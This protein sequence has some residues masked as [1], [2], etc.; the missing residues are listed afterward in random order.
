M[1]ADTKAAL[2][3][4]IAAHLADEADGAMVTAYTLVVANITG[5]PAMSLPL[6]WT[7]PTTE[8][9][10]GL[11]IGTHALTRPGADARL[12]SLAGQLE[13][14][15]PWAH[16]WPALAFEA[17]YAAGAT[18]AGVAWPPRGDQDRHR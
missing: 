13:R 10:R 1:S 8:A 6:H 2:D 12:F 15:Q 16:R 14:A 5:A 17:A 9:P 4:A 18:D 3:E 11:P 7:E